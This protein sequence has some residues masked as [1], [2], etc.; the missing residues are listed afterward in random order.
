[1]LRITINTVR[2]AVAR[3]RVALAV[4]AAMASALPSALVA[5]AALGAPFI[6]RST[7]SFYS[8]EISRTGGPASTEMYGLAYGHRF[9][10]SGNPTRLTMQLRG[11]TR[12]FDSEKPSVADLSALVGL[13]RE[14]AAVPGLSLAVSTGVDAT[15]WGDDAGNTSRAHLRVPASVGV[16]YDIRVKGATFT[17]FA[18]SSIS[19][20]DIR[21]YVNDV[22]QSR[23][24]GWDVSYVTGASLRF[25]N[26]V[27]MTNRIAS[28]YG[29]PKDHRWAM[30]A[31]ISF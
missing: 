12:P 28:E 14:V 22:E 17:P 2:N 8:A 18:M 16:S 24:Q 4:V 19:R 25:N 20:Y 6:G 11:S 9:G 3:P 7:L 26:I 15:A 29:M 23:N 1:M 27:L 21:T 31:G 5:Q 13:E 30:S 10:Q